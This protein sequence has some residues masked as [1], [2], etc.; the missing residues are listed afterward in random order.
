MTETG[1]DSGK[2]GHVLHGFVAPERRLFA[3]Y[4]QPV[5]AAQTTAFVICPPLG[6]E[7]VHCHHTIRILAEELAANGLPVLRIHYDG[8]GESAGSDVDPGR[9]EAWLSS[10]ETAMGVAR[11]LDHVERVGLIGIRI[12]ATLAAAV[13]SRCSVSDLVLWEPCLSGAMY[14][15]EMQI[16][17]SATAKKLEASAGAVPDVPGIP[18]GLQAGGYLL[19]PATMQDLS[20]LKLDE[21]KPL[22]R[23]RT[24]LIQRDD[25]PPNARLVEQLLDAGF[26][27]A[28]EQIPGHSEMMTGAHPMSS[29][30]P[31]KIVARIAAWAVDGSENYGQPVNTVPPLVE[32]TQCDGLRRKIVN[33]GPDK[34]MFGIITE[35]VGGGVAGQPDVV[36]FSGGV[37][38]RTAVNRTYVYLAERLA[39]DGHRV[40][41]FDVSGIGESKPATGNQQNEIFPTTLLPDAGAALEFMAGQDKDRRLWLIGLCSGGASAFQTAIADERVAGVVM[42]NPAAFYWEPGVDP[43]SMNVKQFAE[44][45]RYGESMLDT[46]KWTKLMSGQVKIMPIV[47]LL[48]SRVS[49]WLA[50]RWARTSLF[51]LKRA[52]GLAPDL[53]RLRRRGVS[54]NLAFSPED[55]S[56]ELLKGLV[57]KQLESL[58]NEG[59]VIRRFQGADHTFNP[60][61]PRLQLIDWVSGLVS[62]STAA[63]VASGNSGNT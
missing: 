26:D 27:A 33:F 55:Y 10:I 50:T 39:H 51:G 17:A 36:L 1:S 13:S 63:P 15:R 12:G 42:I 52:E 38:P 24:L 54:V 60:L 57:G 44:T 8:T 16:L 49:N 11:D 47:T 9:V 58:E 35:P 59:I 56:Y 48:M 7:G 28:A 14:T 32:E 25:R 2:P 34:R 62:G 23:P 6:Y 20:S 29:I 37:V 45:K 22:G 19:T 41:R 61:G 18:D 43:A 4:H 40:L 31:E 3:H 46:S 30:V 5:G 53:T 21:Q